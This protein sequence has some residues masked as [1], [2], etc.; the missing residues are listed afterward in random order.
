MAQGR[1]CRRRKF[2]IVRG[3]KRDGSGRKQIK[4]KRLPYTVRITAAQ[5]EKL[6]SLGGSEWLIK[7]LEKA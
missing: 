7:M 5:R 1:I 4:D 2:L 6:E 3:G